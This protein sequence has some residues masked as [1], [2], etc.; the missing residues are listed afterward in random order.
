MDVKMYRYSCI[1]R[2]APTVDRTISSKNG[3]KTGS[4]KAFFLVF[5]TVNA[6]PAL[7][8]VA[9]KAR[10]YCASR[11]ERWR[12]CTEPVRAVNPIQS[13]GGPRPQK[14]ATAP[15]C[16]TCYTTKAHLRV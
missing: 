11:S 3:R 7:T 9:P 1:L 10:T 14:N 5:G 6:Y 16:T 4:C 8:C 2:H 12:G 13:K 15:E